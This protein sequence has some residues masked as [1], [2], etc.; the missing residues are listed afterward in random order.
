MKLAV[1]GYYLQNRGTPGDSHTSAYEKAPEGLHRSSA[2][3]SS[4]RLPRAL[5]PT[6]IPAGACRDMLGASAAAL[7]GRAADPQGQSGPTRADGN[8]IVKSSRAGPSTRVDACCAP[9]P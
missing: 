4:P 1:F 8:T 6:G 5:L 3:G 9:A 7:T 2:Y